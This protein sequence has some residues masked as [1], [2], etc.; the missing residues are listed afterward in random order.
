MSRRHPGQLTL[1]EATEV[2]GD[3]ADIGRLMTKCVGR[4]I[5]SDGTVPVSE[6]EVSTIV[7]ILGRDG[8]RPPRGRHTQP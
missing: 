5:D 4:R 3:T 8:G 1:A 7:R 2:L 6:A